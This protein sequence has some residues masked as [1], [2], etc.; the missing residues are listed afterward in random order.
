MYNKLINIKYPIIIY[1]KI[2]YNL[3]K[4]KIIFIYF[5]NMETQKVQYQY[6]FFFFA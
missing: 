6:N 2:V 4:F 5:I 1:F 3:L